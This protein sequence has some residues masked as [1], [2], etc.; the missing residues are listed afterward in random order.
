M[1]KLILI[2]HGETNKNVKNRLHASDDPET[3]NEIGR[4]QIQKTAEALKQYSPSK[5]FSSKET[6]AIESAEIIAKQLAIPTEKVE[7]LQERN[8]GAFTGKPWEEVKKVLD[9]MT[10]EERYDY[11]PPNGE[12]WRI[13]ENRLIEAIKTILESNQGETIA[14][15]THGGA[16]RALM[17]FL[18]NVSKQES[19]KYDPDNASLTIMAIS[20]EGFQPVMVNDTTHLSDK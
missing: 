14:V 9:P 2:R 17:P 7:G 11:V 19:F 15:V 10:L 4:V 5:I 8:W 3:L 20:G 1:E 18:L 12:S 13:F 6:R 16:I